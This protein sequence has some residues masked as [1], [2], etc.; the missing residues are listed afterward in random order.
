M[1]DGGKG[2]LNV[3][4]A[5]LREAGE[6]A[7]PILR[8]LLADDARAVDVPTDGTAGASFYGKETG[9]TARIDTDGFDLANRTSALGQRPYS[10]PSVFNYYSPFSRIPGR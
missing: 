1:I 5:A 2:Q 10:S 6:A 3:A 8:P 4:R 9:G 7:I